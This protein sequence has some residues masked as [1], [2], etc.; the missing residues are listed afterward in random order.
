[1][2]VSVGDLHIGVRSTNADLA[3]RVRVALREHVVH[4]VDA[5]PN[6]SLVLGDSD[7]ASGAFHFL[8]RGST[9]VV[10]TRDPDR[11]VRALLNHLSGHGEVPADHVRVQAVALVGDR[12]ALLAPFVIRQH[13]DHVERRLHAAG[14]RVSDTEL[15]QVDWHRRVL[16]VPE[17]ALAIDW[18][19]L[20]DL[21][22]I[23][24][25][26]VVDPI[27][28][29]G[30]YPVFGWAFLGEGDPPSRARAVALGMRLVTDPPPAGDLQH[31]LDALGHLME[32]VTP[33]R[34]TW[35][36]PARLAAPLIEMM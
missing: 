12:G 27:V 14:V 21:A 18:S 29:P 15:T 2:T 22:S 20:D 30:D 26:V 9:R 31:A 13:A 33:L 28:A 23:V 1:M 19:A 5:P 3:A 8:Y 17:P 36:K 4:D 32:T 7:G 24:P 34:L 11:L 6:Y 25:T 10:R 35:T 16:V